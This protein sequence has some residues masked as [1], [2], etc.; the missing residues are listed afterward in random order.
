MQLLK[1]QQQT[2]KRVK[3]GLNHRN[4]RTFTQIWESYKQKN[5]MTCAVHQIAGL[6][7]ETDGDEV[8]ISAT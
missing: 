5:F 7:H 2:T 1:L 8:R 4:G 6:S 3:L